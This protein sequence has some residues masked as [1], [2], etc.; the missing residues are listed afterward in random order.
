MS[1]PQ[2]QTPAAEPAFNLLDEAW[3]PV[4]W[5]DGNTNSI[6]LR[7][8]FARSASITGLAEPSPPAFVALHRLLLAI[9]HRALT[10]HQ[11]RW[12]D[13]DRA[14]W[15]HEGLPLQAFEHYLE[16][17]RARFWLFHPT[18]PFMQVAALANASQ[19]QSLK[20]WTQVSLESAGGN[21]PVIFDHSVDDAPSTVSAATVLRSM[22]GCLQFT[23]GGPVKVLRKDGYGRKG[24]LFDSAAILPTG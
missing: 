10:L 23:A 12:T 9:T 1:S 19:L 11:G 6:G 4:R 5:L 15:Y 7:E 3:L 13:A 2:V 24:A 22:L 17:W 18:Q 21:N 8:L 20:P 16:K 14:R